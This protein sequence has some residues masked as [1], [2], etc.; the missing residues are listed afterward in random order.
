[1]SLCHGIKQQNACFFIIVGNR[2]LGNRRAERLCCSLD[3]LSYDDFFLPVG[4]KDGDTNL[5]S[6]N[7]AL[8]D[9]V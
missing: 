2:S 4:R 6:Q 8:P 1:M 7:V 9:P 5:N 3:V